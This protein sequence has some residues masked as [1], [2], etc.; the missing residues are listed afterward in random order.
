MNNFKFNIFLKLFKLIFYIIL[1]D[2][3]I[4]LLSRL[5]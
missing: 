3:K 4:I 2:I 5:I 1:N